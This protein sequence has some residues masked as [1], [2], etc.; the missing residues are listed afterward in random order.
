MIVPLLK[1]RFVDELHWIDEEEMLDLIAVAQSA[2]GPIAVNTSLMIGFQKAGF[3]GGLVTTAGTIL[4]PFL[5][6]LLVSLVYQ[7]LRENPLVSRIMAGL[8]VG[9]LVLIVQAVLELGK[10]ALKQ[11]RIFSAS[12]LILAWLASMVLKVSILWIILSAAL[13]GLI[14]NWI[15]SRN[16]RVKE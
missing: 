12:I 14:Y 5:I 10:A 7:Q 15:L 1:K 16:R 4:P 8:L 13:A 2:P 11:E 9:V 3:L 6:I